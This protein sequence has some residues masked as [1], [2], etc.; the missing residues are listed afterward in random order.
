MKKLLLLGLAFSIGYCANAQN[1]SKS[2]VSKNV[3]RVS[4][5]VLKKITGNEVIPVV[6]QEN[7]YYTMSKKSI[8]LL[9]GEPIG[10]T[11]YD[12]QT[13]SGICNRIVQEPNGNVSAVWTMALV[14]NFADRGTGYNYWNGTAWLDAP[15]ARIEGT[16]R[17]GW[18]NIAI[19]GTD[20]MVVSHNAN[21]AN[22]NTKPISGT[23]WTDESFP[24][25]NSMTWPRMVANGNTIHV[26][27]V[28]DYSAPFGTTGFLSGALVYWRSTDGGL[29]WVDQ[30]RLLP[31]MDTIHFSPK[32]N[33]QD[34][35]SM[36]IKG[37][38]VVIA[39]GNVLSGA[40]IWKS[41]D[42]GV[43]WNFIDIL[44]SPARKFWFNGGVPLDFNNDAQQDGIF[45]SDGSQCV[46]LDINGKAHVFF[47]FMR[48]TS[49]GAGYSYYP[50]YDGI[51]YWN[52]DMGTI[53]Y[54]YYWDDPTGTPTYCAIPDTTNFKII[55]W[56]KDLNGNGEIDWS[57]A[58]VSGN[59]YGFYQTS[60]TSQITA[61]VDKKNV[62]HIVYS[63]IVDGAWATV[64]STAGSFDRN[65]RNLWMLHHDIASPS[66]LT[67]EYDHNY[68]DSGRIISD[69]ISEEVYP[70]MLRKPFSYDPENDSATVAFTYIYDVYPGNSL[71][72]TPPNHGPVEN[73]IYFKTIKI[74]SNTVGIKEIEVV[75]NAPV[76]YPNPTSNNVTISYNLINAANVTLSI[77]NT[78]GQQIMT[79]N[80]N[81]AAGEV[82]VALDIQ[83][84][85]QGVYF[86]KSD[87][88]NKTYT[89]K[90]IV[91]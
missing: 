26:I 80:K 34:D 3:Q 60:L 91:K 6:F 87:I 33:Y 57:P 83:S 90:L 17:T 65:Y 22:K 70:N 74:E 59:Q 61:C 88:G 89:N 35:Y 58:A 23:T 21:A 43:N 67:W 32:P 19:T 66:Y 47:G 38:T 54:D 44:P 52:E 20:Q 14:S 13:N 25:P 7:N 1:N 71:Q 51:W 68:L 62:I 77:Y 9:F 24:A 45:G 31:N 11:F 2:L 50:G 73:T 48:N 86:I 76:V 63:S 81:V 79:T 12:L 28:A 55:T 72:P 29:N 53:S 15:T 46:V 30:D 10:T 56:I 18:P 8:D 37:D 49:D 69:N 82:N 85:T 39:V 42:A 75:K 64:P 27:G 40:F 78:V 36:D 4:V 41:T 84:L 5:P 16:T